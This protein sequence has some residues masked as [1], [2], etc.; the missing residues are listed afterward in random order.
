M[1]AIG[2]EL[3]HIETAKLQDVKGFLSLNIIVLLMPYW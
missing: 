3:A 1:D 2:K